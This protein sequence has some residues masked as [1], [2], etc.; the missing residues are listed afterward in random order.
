MTNTKVP[1][2]RDLFLSFCKV[3]TVCELSAAGRR[4]VSNTF[5]VEEHTLEAAA[6]S[7]RES[8]G[9]A[10]KVLVSYVN[11]DGTPKPLA[12]GKI[13]DPLPAIV[14]R[15]ANAW[16]AIFSATEQEVIDYLAGRRK[17]L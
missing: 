15:Y 17:E 2:R 7:V 8:A 10:V 12:N 16:R 6:E 5:F 1:A 11:D 9:I 13:A 3:E 4:P 14:V